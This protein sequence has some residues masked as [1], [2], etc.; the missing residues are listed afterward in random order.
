MG[1]DE[2]KLLNRMQ[3]ATLVLTTYINFGALSM[4]YLEVSKGLAVYVDPKKIEVYN[5]QIEAIGVVMQILT[6]GLFLSFGGV[7]MKKLLTAAQDVSLDDVKRRAAGV[8]SRVRSLTARSRGAS[9]ETP[10][11]GAAPE[12]ELRA[13]RSGG[14][15]S[16]TNPGDKS[17]R[18]LS[19]EARL[20]VP[21]PV[22]FR[23]VQA[24]ARRP[25]RK[26]WSQATDPQGRP[27]FYCEATDE[28]AWTLPAGAVLVNEDDSQRQNH[29]IRLP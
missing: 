4:N 26:G 29:C 24:E 14:Q 9:A 20:T 5:D 28:T 6:F 1:G 2:A 11:L 7:A 22:G 21:S 8:Q 16:L 18:N 17:T 23:T 13:M 15:A 27:Y 12:L 19:T 25:A 3:T 10:R